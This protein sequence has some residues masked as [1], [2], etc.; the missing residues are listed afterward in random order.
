MRSLQCGL[1]VML[2]GLLA[3]LLVQGQTSPAADVRRQEI[4]RQR[5]DADLERRIT[6]LHTLEQRMRA[7]SR[8]MPPPPQE[9]R[10]TKEQREH[11][12]QLRRVSP[13]DLDR[14]GAL[15]AQ[16]NT[17]IFKLFPDTGCLSKNVIRVGGDCD[18]F[19][20]L[21]S[22][23][24]FRT[25]NYGDEVYHDIRFERDQ[26]LNH[27]FF[28]Q[29]IL[30][31]IGDADIGDVDLNNPAV[32]F[33]TDYTEDI[34]A[35]SA[36]EHAKQFQKGVESG[37]FTYSDSVA[38]KED[39]TYILRT[40]AYRLENSLRPI[41]ESSTMNEMMFHSLS[42]D[43]RLDVIVVFR[44][45]GKDENGGVTIV[46]KELARKDAGKIK[47]A[48]GAALEDFKPYRRESR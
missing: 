48:K 28:S 4:D 43:K 19:V 20:P 24:T 8:R 17:G 31:S 16:P 23:F 30:S 29:G 45:L 11:I 14:Y 18:K 39:S 12:L 6:D 35:K 3:P 32:K 44:I 2:S 34:D 42:M 10:L 7:D 5:A 27:S 47:F 41:S 40:I 13:S 36:A 1:I 21:S 22:S 9:P 37:G 15:L 38:V 46:W 26:I 33:L 25:N